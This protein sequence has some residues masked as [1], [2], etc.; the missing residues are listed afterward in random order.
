M[1]PDIVQ[2]SDD[3][4]GL[5]RRWRFVEIADDSFR[6]IGDAS[7]D[8]GATWTVELEYRATRQE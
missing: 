2:I 6:W 7:W 8:K 1:G 5:R 4:S 3:A